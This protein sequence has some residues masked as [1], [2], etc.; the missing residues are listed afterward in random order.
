MGHFFK[1]YV[2]EEVTPAVQHKSLIYSFRDF[3]LHYE[4][5]ASGEISLYSGGFIGRVYVNETI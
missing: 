5:L 2:H 3:L 1:S 4:I